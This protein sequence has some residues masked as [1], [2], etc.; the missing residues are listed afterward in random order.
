METDDVANHFMALGVD[1]ESAVEDGIFACKRWQ[2]HR[3][4]KNIPHSV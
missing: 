2:T 4:R 1:A 3:Y